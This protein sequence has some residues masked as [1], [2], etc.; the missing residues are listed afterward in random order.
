[1]TITASTAVTAVT[2]AGLLPPDTTRER[3]GLPAAGPPLQWQVE[4]EPSAHVAGARRVREPVQPCSVPRR[5]C[6]GSAILSPV[7]ARVLL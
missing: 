1:M 3:A 6:S 2:A 7:P 4:A 5:L